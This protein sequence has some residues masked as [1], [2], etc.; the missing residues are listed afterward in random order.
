MTDDIV[1]DQNESIEIKSQKLKGWKEK[2]QNSLVKKNENLLLAELKEVID[3]YKIPVHPF[4]DLIDGVEMDLIKNRYENF[5]ELK[6]YCYGVASTVGLM[7]IPIFGYKNKDTE[8]FAVNLGIALQLTNIIRDVKFDA[9]NDRIY[10]PQDEIIK[11]DYSEK[12]L[13]NSVYNAKFFELMKYQTDRAK[14]FYSTADK[15]LVS[16]DKHSMYT[17]RAMEYIYKRLLDNIVNEKYNVFGQ[18]IIISNFNK[19]FISLAVFLK[20]KTIYKW[21]SA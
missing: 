7:T 5:D 21:L 1:D 8:K 15:F 6:K 19:I 10:I 2:F 18:K 16:K 20:Y 12:E 9:L 3:L 17:A 14:Y 13:H 11:F 4:L